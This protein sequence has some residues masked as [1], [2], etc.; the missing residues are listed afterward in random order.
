M[1]VHCSACTIAG[2]KYINVWNMNISVCILQ[3]VLSWL[4][5]PDNETIKI[6]IS[7][8]CSPVVYF[9]KQYSLF[10]NFVYSIWISCMKI[11]VVFFKIWFCCTLFAWVLDYF[12]R[13]ACWC[14]CFILSVILFIYLL[15]AFL[16]VCMYKRSTDCYCLYRHRFQRHSWRFLYSA[17]SPILSL[18]IKWD[19]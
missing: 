4:I 19:L 13:F 9:L 2:T 3:S 16:T 5:F 10:A 1:R 12:V 6:C 8:I 7:T 17:L 18:D 15:L 11:M 14:D